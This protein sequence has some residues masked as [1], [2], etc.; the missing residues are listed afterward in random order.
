MGRAGN[1]GERKTTAEGEAAGRKVRESLTPHCPPSFSA[2]PS[3]PPAPRPWWLSG[4]CRDFDVVLHERHTCDAKWRSN[5]ARGFCV[6]SLKT[7]WILE[8]LWVWNL[9]RRTKHYYLQLM[10]G[11]EELVVRVS[12]CSDRKCVQQSLVAHVL[13][14][15]LRTQVL[16]KY[17]KGMP[18]CLNSYNIFPSRI[19]ERMVVYSMFYA[20]CLFT[21]CMG[22]AD[23]CL[24]CTWLS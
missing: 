21:K 11:A 13:F 12:N 7:T 10:Q 3:F 8:Y 1:L 20:C 15:L 5:V 6:I 16:T 24:Y 18:V 23:I 19:C 9:E 17:S 4:P 14:L 2:R 22:L